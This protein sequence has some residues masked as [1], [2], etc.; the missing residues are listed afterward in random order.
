MHRNDKLPN[1]GKATLSGYS[2]EHVRP[3]CWGMLAH[4]LG[5]SDDAQAQ[6]EKVEKNEAPPALQKLAHELR[7]YS[8]SPAKDRA[9]ILVR[10]VECLGVLIDPRKCDGRGPAMCQEPPRGPDDR[11]ARDGP[12]TGYSR[13]PFRELGDGP[14]PRKTVA[15]AAI[16]YL[17][18]AY[19]LFF[20]RP[21]RF[22]DFNAAK[23]ALNDIFQATQLGVRLYYSLAE[24]HL[25]PWFKRSENG[26]DARKATQKGYFRRVKIGCNFNSDPWKSPFFVWSMLQL[27]EIQRGNIYRKVE[28]ID[29][30]DRCYS[31]AQR[32]LDR[33]CADHFAIDRSKI[34]SK[35]D[36]WFITPTMV[37]ALF[38]RSKVLFDKG[39]FIESIMNQLRC[40]GYLVHVSKGFGC[41]KDDSATESLIPLSHAMNFLDVVRRQSVWDKDSIT[42]LFGLPSKLTPITGRTI[43]P[44]DL[45]AHMNGLSP[46]NAQ[47]AVEI[48]ARLGFTI[49]LLRR[50]GYVGACLPEELST[51]N[52]EPSTVNEEG[53]K[54][55]KA[56]LPFFEAHLA[57][58]LKGKSE[59]SAEG[60]YWLKFIATGHYLRGGGVRDVEFPDHLERQLAHR[61]GQTIRVKPYDGKESE[62]RNFYR[63]VFGSVTQNIGNLLTIP[64]RLHSFLMRPGYL[65][66]RSR[67]DLS[68]GTV[69]QS[70]P[71]E[72]LKYSRKYSGADDLAGKPSAVDGKLV[73]LRRWQSFNP[74]IPRPYGTEVRG[75]GYFLLWNG[76]GVVVDPGYDFIQNFYDEGFSLND[77]DAVMVTHSHPDHDDDLSS[78]TTLVR[79]WNEFHKLVGYDTET[80]G[81]EDNEGSTDEAALIHER[82]NR[83]KK[84]DV[85]LNESTHL[86]FSNWLRASKVGIARI[87]PLPL[88][89]WNMEPETE[90]N[91]E[92]GS[93]SVRGENVTL[94]LRKSYGFDLQVIP[95]RHDDVIGRTSAVGL[96]F[97]LYSE[98]S[99]KAASETLE[100]ADPLAVVGY[101]GD[102]GM[103]G[104]VDNRDI[105]IQAYYEN[106]DVL[107]AHLGDIRLRELATV[108][109]EQGKDNFVCECISDV[110]ADWFR[111]ATGG[112]VSGRRRGY[113]TSKVAEELVNSERV[114]S[115]LRMLVDLRVAPEWALQTKIRTSDKK[116]TTVSRALR[117]FILK[118]TT[119]LKA[120]PRKTL[121]AGLKSHLPKRL[122]EN[123]E[124]TEDLM[125]DMTK[126]LNEQFASTKHFTSKGK[127]QVYSLLAYLCASS[128]KP[129]SYRDHLGVSGIFRLHKTIAGS[130]REGN[131]DRLFIIGELPEELASYR[132]F[133]ARH[134][135]AI[136]K[137]KDDDGGQN[138]N[139]DQG[140]VYSFT[141]DIGLH[142]KLGITNGRFAPKIL[143]AYCDYNNETVLAKENYHEPALILETPL[144]RLNSA[145]IYLCTKHDH[146]PADTE[147]P[148]DF[149]S[150]PNLR[151][152]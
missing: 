143:C 110:L 46:S 58:G 52:E 38:E 55:E 61:L 104:D 136:N 50:R 126:I 138:F 107:V 27:V 21:R 23:V 13:D 102:T 33:L 36:K 89:V 124:D 12:D 142:I 32:R 125:N 14:E 49:F 151:V 75:G 130:T 91:T 140:R 60:R 100:K 117:R 63:S 72:L 83:I 135:N 139:A 69:C 111:E 51:E 8:V 64:R 59:A 48:F 127:R 98:S 95:A 105:N 10:V 19:A 30:A 120:G 74:K 103:Y 133:I 53:Q 40:L 112:G 77:I 80:S 119:G 28:Y 73:V 62:D 96:K 16:S 56:L 129:W 97:F 4:M 17:M 141:G 44:G 45:A 146:H 66:R 90:S 6:L 42:S 47:T 57:K 92:S 71:A 121:M 145:M 132:H 15:L 18:R 137:A 3:L 109:K 82:M 68:R 7:H 41:N 54:V 67:G 101:T 118:G 94:N 149:L 24:S 70:L 35:K 20:C 85:F 2:A 122:P 29:E 5:L 31:H 106:C 22:R 113:A 43:L 25:H 9:G 116:N 39:L 123:F 108:L 93:S 11:K 65:D 115:F 84:L 1:E 87:I 128:L 144:K 78:L 114:D 81:T 86:K 26:P 134:L 34:V 148:A 79:E 99:R 150:R 37:K 131:R 88:L 152:I 76:R 147:R